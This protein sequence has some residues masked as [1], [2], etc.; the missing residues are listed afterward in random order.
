[1]EQYVG[2]DA[3]F[4]ETSICV[5]DQSGAVVSE[6]SAPSR[7]EAIAKALRRRAPK[8][9]RIIFET[10]SLANMA[11]LMQAQLAW[12]KASRGRNRT[13][14]KIF[15]AAEW[16]SQQAE[17]HLDCVLG[18]AMLIELVEPCMD[19]LDAAILQVSELQHSVSPIV[20]SGT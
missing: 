2:L 5:L 16:A 4:E 11:P 13:S 1:M 10:G 12:W 8:A 6:G 20:E 7:P 17:M 18:G 19:R 3:S 15:P 9:S 14:C